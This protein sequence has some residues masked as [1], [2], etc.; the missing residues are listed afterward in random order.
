[1]QSHLRASP[2]QRNRSQ[3]VDF[4]QGVE[5]LHLGAASALRGVPIE[6]ARIPRLDQGSEPGKFVAGGGGEPERRSTGRCGVEPH[7]GRASSDPLHGTPVLN[8]ESPVFPAFVKY[9]GFRVPCPEAL[10]RGP[11]GGVPLALLG[12]KAWYLHPMF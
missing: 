5:T 6:P 1:M 4:L 8:D 2:A 9:G 12:L 7:A 3:P 11:H 10:G